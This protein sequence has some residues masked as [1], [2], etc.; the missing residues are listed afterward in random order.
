MCYC[1]CFYEDYN[2]D[3]RKPRNLPCPENQEEVDAYE[4]EMDRR[5]DAWVDEQLAKQLG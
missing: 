2:G 3:C 5:Y 4:T 1:G